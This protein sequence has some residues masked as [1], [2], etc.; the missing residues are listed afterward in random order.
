MQ[1]IQIT[2]FGG[3]EVLFSADVP[4]PAVPAD[5]TLIEV[6]LAGVNYADTHSVDNSY[7]TEAELPLVPGTEVYGHTADGRR[8]VAIVDSGGYAQR[9]AAPSRHVYDVPP[10]VPGP[11]ALALPVQG[12]TAWHLLRTAARMTAGESVVVHAAAGGTGSLAVQ[13]ARIFGAGRV[14]AVASTAQKRALAERMGADAA[15]D[16]DHRGLADRLMR[17]NG[18]NPVD[19]ILEMTGGHVFEASLD[20]L[21]P[22]GRLVCYGMASR[23]PPR[24]VQPGR[25]MS[26]SK[27]VV[28][29]WLQHCMDRPELHAAPMEKLL[30]LVREGSLEPLIGRTYPL[31]RARAAHEDLRARRTVGKVYLDPAH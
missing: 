26:T 17:A 12:L 18:G 6:E 30:Q 10:D 11:A 3:P 8:V 23:L 9:V 20:A 13:L 29:F 14:I 4:E 5:H 21:A 16:G 7:M 27:A 1:A 2:G 24:P 31:S 28:G 15:I 22:L 19:V 25:L